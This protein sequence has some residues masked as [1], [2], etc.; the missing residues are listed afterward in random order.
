VR[1]IKTPVLRDVEWMISQD[2]R[3]CELQGK[4]YCLVGSRG[5][6]KSIIAA[7]R[8]GWLYTFFNN[9]QSVISAGKQG[10]IKLVT[11]KIEDGLTNLHPIFIKNRLSSDWKKE[12]MAGWKDKT[13][14]APHAKSSKSQ[15]L[16]KNF[17]DG[18]DS[19]VI[20]HYCMAI[21]STSLPSHYRTTFLKKPLHAEHLNIPPAIHIH[22]Q[23]LVRHRT[24]RPSRNRHLSFRISVPPSD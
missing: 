14:N 1:E 17:Q 16:M 13:T 5:F 22:Q 19:M 23:L 18:N 9:S 12:I 6:G 4:F 11:D 15:I 7:S 20:I 8:S 24:G 10:Y 3:Q 21:L 2:L